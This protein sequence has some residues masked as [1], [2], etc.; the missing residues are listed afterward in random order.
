MSLPL[1][2]YV[3]ALRAYLEKA[4]DAAR[5]DARELGRRALEN[6]FELRDATHLHRA[7]VDAL[8]APAGS[9]TGIEPARSAARF[10]EE[11]LAPFGA[12]VQ[13]WQ[14]AND[15]LSALSQAVSHD[16]RAPLR[17][18]DGFSQ[19]LL[20]DYSAGLDESGKQYLG[21][22]REAAQHMAELIS[23]LLSL[24]RIS[25]AEMQPV[26]ADLSALAR[27]IC[28]GLRASSP[29]RNADFIIQ[30][31]VRANGDSRLLT[32]LLEQLL[33]NAWK[34]TAKRARALVAFGCKE[35]AGQL[36]YFVRDNGAGFDMAHAGKLFGPF[37]RLHPASEFS[38]TG[39][40]LATAQRIVHRHRGRIWAESSVDGGA[41]FTFTLGAGG[42]P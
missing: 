37:Q 36:R 30:D 35:Q 17:S 19:L 6:G 9:F 20:E 22:V 11:F 33:G 28:E 5:A 15:E 29:E 21:R 41:V 25:R 18:I 39:I 8:V 38:G 12:A 10:F 34:F 14:A 24:T 3:A 4:T 40:G 26:D 7:A 31:G 2:E 16:L 1:D 42:K 23:A 13:E 32:V 27:R